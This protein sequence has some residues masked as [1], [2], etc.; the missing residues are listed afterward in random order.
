MSFED[1]LKLA[2]GIKGDKGATKLALKS[3]EKA[4]LIPQGSTAE[5]VELIEQ[6]QKRNRDD[7][8]WLE[9]NYGHIKVYT[10]H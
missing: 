8:A 3:M 5:I 9:G 6:I 2:K 1:Y 7:L 10:N 4:H